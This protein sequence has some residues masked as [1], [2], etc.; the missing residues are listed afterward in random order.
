MQPFE[1][2][3]RLGISHITDFQGYDHMVFLIA[4][5]VNYSFRDWKKVL[6]VISFFTIGHTITLGLAATGIVSLHPPTVEFLIALT[7][8]LTGIGNLTKRGQQSVGK[9]RYWL[10]GVFGLIHGLGFSGYYSM[11]AEGANPWVSLPAFTLGIELGQVIVVIAYMIL[12]QLIL[13]A[14]T[15]SKRDWMLVIS[16]GV[17]GIAVVMML[18][19]LPQLF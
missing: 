4:L 3:L 18:E 12:A 19:R 17:I 6:F 7:I 2:F 16:G 1:L 14:F 10:G 11:I 5:C 8:L 13:T 9:F 15:I